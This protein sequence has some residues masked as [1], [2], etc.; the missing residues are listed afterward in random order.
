MI[1]GVFY[2]PG[3]G[4]GA[5]IPVGSVDGGWKCCETTSGGFA[6][7]S[8]ANCARDSVTSADP[9]S[10]LR[11][12][13]SHVRHFDKLLPSAGH[14]V[15]KVHHGDRTGPKKGPK[16]PHQGGSGG[17]HSHPVP[18]TTVKPSAGHKYYIQQ[19]PLCTMRFPPGPHYTLI[20][21]TASCQETFTFT[22]PSPDG[23]LALGTI[24]GSDLCHGS[25][26]VAWSCIMSSPDC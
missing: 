9:A 17:N 12:N 23:N 1:P 7:P 2:N 5:C 4:G 14:S 15:N 13:N 21:C 18:V 16:S 20:M 10:E 8:D 25:T 26:A 3:Y 22:G 11:G 24:E 19:A 6:D